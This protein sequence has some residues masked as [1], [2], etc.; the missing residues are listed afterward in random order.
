MTNKRRKE[1]PRGLTVQPRNGFTNEKMLFSKKQQQNPHWQTKD[2]N[3]TIKKID[4]N[5]LTLILENDFLE[6]SI[7]KTKKDNKTFKK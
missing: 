3:I 4:L 1:L 7:R 5:Y 6:K 2:I